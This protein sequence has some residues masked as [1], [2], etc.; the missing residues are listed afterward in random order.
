MQSNGKIRIAVASFLVGLALPSAISTAATV[1]T[2][3]SHG[4]VDGGFDVMLALRAVQPKQQIQP[5]CL[6]S[7]QRI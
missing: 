4:W 2:F 6:D 5:S 1:G 3:L 7:G